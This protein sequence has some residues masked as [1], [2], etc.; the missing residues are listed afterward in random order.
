MQDIYNIYFLRSV[1]YKGV[2]LEIPDLVKTY[3]DYRICGIAVEE[4]NPKNIRYVNSEEDTHYD[5]LNY[6]NEFF[7]SWREIIYIML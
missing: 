2:T 4:N 5:D 3:S 1:V 7:Y 6:P